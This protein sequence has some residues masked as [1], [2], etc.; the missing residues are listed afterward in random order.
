[1]SS[2]RRTE[3]CCD[4]GAA[5]VDLEFIERLEQDDL[6]WEVS[7]VS[8]VCEKD[9]VA[10]K[11]VQTDMEYYDENTFEPLDATL[12]A[13]AESEGLERFTKMGVYE[14]CKREDAITDEDAKFVKVKWVRTNK[15]TPTD[16]KVRCR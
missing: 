13:A 3:E 11:Q 8:T 14:H 12:V 5:E 15:G 1:M 10:I 6:K 9:D 7:N 2:G 16:P 4:D